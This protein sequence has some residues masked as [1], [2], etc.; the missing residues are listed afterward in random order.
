M[1]LAT[2]FASIV[3]I[4]YN[5][6]TNKVFLICFRVFICWNCTILNPV[7]HVTI[8]HLI[9]IVY[10]FRVFIVSIPTE[11]SMGFFYCIRIST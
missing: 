4:L 5:V 11:F 8:E 6:V 9:G 7:F 1:L 10:Q 3:I 2:S